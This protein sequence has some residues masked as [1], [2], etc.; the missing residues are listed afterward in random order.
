MGA[1]YTIWKKHANNG[2][3]NGNGININGSATFN[4]SGTAYQKMV[5]TYDGTEWLAH[6]D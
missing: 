4:F 3:I 6:Q 1:E 2:T 5:I